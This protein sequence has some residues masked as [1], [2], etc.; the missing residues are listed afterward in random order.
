MF[1]SDILD[2][3]CNL[4]SAMVNQPLP[5]KRPRRH[6]DS[7]EGT[8]WKKRVVNTRPT[9]VAALLY[10]RRLQSL[11]NDDRL[12]DLVTYEFHSVEPLSEGLEVEYEYSLF[13][14]P[15]S[16]GR[17]LIK[18][19]HET[20]KSLFRG[21]QTSFGV[22]FAQLDPKNLLPAFQLDETGMSLKWKQESMPLLG[23]RVKGPFGFF[24]IKVSTHLNSLIVTDEQGIIDATGLVDYLIPTL[25]WT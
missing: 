3:T 15:K 12:D 10:A 8:L 14:G 7:P 13:R 20:A 23:F 5:R 1:R 16:P 21:K 24:T 6:S 11:L 22:G 2:S 18:Y 19:P 4:F 9:I 17:T 25:V